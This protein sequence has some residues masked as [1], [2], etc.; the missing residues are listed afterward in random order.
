MSEVHGTPR[1]ADVEMAVMARLRESPDA[2]S[3]R[4]IFEALFDDLSASCSAAPTRLRWTTSSPTPSWWPGGVS[5]SYPPTPPTSGRGSSPWPGV[6][7]EQIDLTIHLADGTVLA[8]VPA[9]DG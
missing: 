7:V 6:G 9:F 2:A 8:G 3:F 5:Q 1:P 4:Q